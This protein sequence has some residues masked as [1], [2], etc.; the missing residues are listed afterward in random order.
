M[1]RIETLTDAQRARFG[2]F[3]RQWTAIGLSTEPADR[4]RAEAAM[5]R[6]Y[7]RAGRV[8]PSRIV[9]CGSP[10][11]MV[12]TRGV[13]LKTPKS[14]DVRDR[15]RNIVRDDVRGNVA[16]NVRDSVAG[17]VLASVQASIDADVWARI[18]RGV[19]ASVDDGVADTLR[20]RVEDIVRFIVNDNATDSVRSRILDIV[21][22]IVNDSVA[23]SVWDSVVS[24][25]RNGVLSRVW[26]VREGIWGSVWDS[27]QDGCWGIIHGQ[28]D[29]IWLALYQYYHD[30]LGLREQTQW[31]DGLWEFA[32]SAGWAIPCRDICFIAERHTTLH[33]DE[34]GRLHCEDGPAVA[35]PDG[36]EIYAVHGVRVPG[37][38]ITDPSRLTIEA[39]HAERNTEIQRV[40]IERFGW[41][42]YAAEC[43]AEIVDHDERWG[44]LY[45][46]QQ[47]G[48]DILFLKVINGSPEPDGSFRQ[49]VLP[50]APN[51]EPLPD[52]DDPNERLGNPQEL[53]ALNA[54]ASTYGLTG[55]D[56]EALV[57]RT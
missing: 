50:V 4:P 45:R 22:I 5:R 37:W 44:T 54:V 27:Y 51:C 16:D 52:P 1:K 13:L 8:P 38:V 40:M 39:I 2:E 3:V 48:E 35:Y 32:Q 42:R 36:W 28:D 29:A 47:D 30:V 20:R 14:E 6:M 46:R 55:H 41:D 25:V 21:R 23:D 34:R 15:V 24:G 56:Y 10:L 12:L 53:T 11:S 49:Y 18:W 31:L 26:N 33:R 7:K 43:G 19:G 9:W 57:V 17:S